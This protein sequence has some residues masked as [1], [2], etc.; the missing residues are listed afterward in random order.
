MG[1]LKKRI[2]DKLLD[3]EK[4][5]FVGRIQINHFLVKKNPLIIRRCAL[6]TGLV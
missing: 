5:H 4:T 1:L 3:Q 2:M 6:R